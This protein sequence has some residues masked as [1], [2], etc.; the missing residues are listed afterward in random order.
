MQV[1]VEWLFASSRDAG[2]AITADVH[3]RH[4]GDSVVGEAAGITGERRRAVIVEPRR[5]PLTVRLFLNPAAA[6]TTLLSVDCS[7]PT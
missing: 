7:L 3:A 2:A 4:E 5:V 6:V 1:A